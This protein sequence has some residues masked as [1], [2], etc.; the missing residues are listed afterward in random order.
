M[1]E[2]SAFRWLYFFPHEW[3][4]HSQKFKYILPLQYLSLMTLHTLTPQRP[5]LWPHTHM[6]AHARTYTHTHTSLEPL[7]NILSNANQAVKNFAFSF[8][9]ISVPQCFRTILLILE[10]VFSQHP[11]I[12]KTKP[13]WVH[14]EWEQKMSKERLVEFQKTSKTTD[15]VF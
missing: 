13:V 4:Y 14:R 11:H 8:L 1:K 6:R 3:N 9:L 2:R 7:T 12:L 10:S 15:T 5:E